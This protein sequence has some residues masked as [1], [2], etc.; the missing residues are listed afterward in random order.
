MVALGIGEMVLKAI[1]FV[2]VAGR[3]ILSAWWSPRPASSTTRW[4]RPRRR[5]RARSW[6]GSPTTWTASFAG[7]TLRE[8]RERL[9]RMM[10]EEKAQ[11]DSHAGA[12]RRAGPGRPRRRRRSRRDGGRHLDAARQASSFSDVARV[13][14][15]FDAF[16]D[17]ARLV[18]ILN[19]CIQGGGVRV[20]I[21]EDRGADRGP[22]VQRRGDPLWPG[23]PAARHAGDRGSLAD[24]VRED[25]PAGQFSR[26][27]PGSRALAEAFSGEAPTA[28]EAAGAGNGG[29]SRRPGDRFFTERMDIV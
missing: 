25:H 27:D 22:R 12:Y 8:I 14:L 18:R 29:N 10:V 20:L 7:Q 11:M 1:D 6:C 5:S 21:G 19:R 9:V 26:R 23:R 15:M 16:A 13:R 4:S 3:K 28:A 17:K 24:G 2:P